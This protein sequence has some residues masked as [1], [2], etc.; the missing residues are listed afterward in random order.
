M[1]LPKLM[2][3]FRLPDIHW[4]PGLIKSLVILVVTLV[5]CGTAL[6]FNDEVKWHAYI[7]HTSVTIS[8]RSVG[9]GLL[10]RIYKSLGGTRKFKRVSL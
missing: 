9:R 1:E 7:K 5:I 10:F 8:S 6:I 3:K 4:T 2:S